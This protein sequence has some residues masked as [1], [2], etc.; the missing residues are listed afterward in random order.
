MTRDPLQEWYEHQREV[1]R[2]ERWQVF[3]T[4]IL[5]TVAAWGVVFFVLFMIATAFLALS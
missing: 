4:I 3:L 1:N 5:L 2:R